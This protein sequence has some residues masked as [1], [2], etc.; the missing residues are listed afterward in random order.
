MTV[1]SMNKKLHSYVMLSRQYYI[2]TD[3][4]QVLYL[5][6]GNDPN[7]LTLIKV[8]SL[9]GQQNRGCTTSQGTGGGEGDRTAIF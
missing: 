6:N 5:Q 1:S 2:F 3:N 4:F 9:S 7:N 8:S